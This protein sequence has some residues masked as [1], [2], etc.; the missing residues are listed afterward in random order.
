MTD[1][2]VRR[3][4]CAQAMVDGALVDGD[5]AVQGERVVDV[6][7]PGGGRGLAVPGLVDLQV[8]GYG[9]CD[10][11]SAD[12]D[13]WVAARQALARDGVTS[14]VANLVT[15]PL[16][17][18]R[19]ALE[20][21]A[22]H[23][24]RAVPGAARLLGAALEGPYL[25][26]ERAGVHRRDALRRPAVEELEHLVA[27]DGVVALTIA[28]ELP[29]A[30]A[31]IRWAAGR[32][33]LVSV[34]HTTCS[35]AQAHAAFD[36]GARTVTHLGNA[37]PAVSAREPGPAAVALTRGD[38][39]VQLICDGVH[40]ADEWVRLAL[41]AA[42]GRWVLVTDAMAAAGCGDGHYRLGERE[43]VVHHGVARDDDGV[44]AGSVASLAGCVREAVR[45]GASE[46][47]ALAA[48][49]AGPARLLRSG[50]PDLGVLRPGG[51]ADVVVLD[52]RL[53]VQRVLV[54]GRAVDAV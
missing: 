7:L 46:L 27:G 37:M 21:V 42:P 22:R 18:T 51:P 6:G 9:G 48:A 47:E 54:G 40:L 11:I 53:E 33:W 39:V 35:A 2:V 45:C 26:P 19:R 23:R 13:D 12:D 29:D 49:T 31:V 16:G 44:L 52:D 32:G 41:A 38:V 14:F 43:V 36:A 15:S 17:V 4:G 10:L 30:L 3:L 20:Q 24:A 28:P 1:D 5:V 8:N 50:P 34:G 25:A